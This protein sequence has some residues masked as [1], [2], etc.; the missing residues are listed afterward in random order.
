MISNLDVET[1]QVAMIGDTE[2][3]HEVAEAMG[4]KCFLMDR[5]H[6]STSR[7]TS[8]QDD[9]FSSFTELLDSI[10]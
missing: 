9:V 3:D 7:L 2:H 5:V 4:V 1:N 6:N 10:A 8:K